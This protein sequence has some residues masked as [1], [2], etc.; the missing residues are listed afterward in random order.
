MTKTTLR[1]IRT[2]L[3]ALPAELDD[4]YDQVFRRIRGQDSE[5]CRLALRTLGW[6]NCALRPLTI[7]ELLHATAVELED[8]TFDTEGIPEFSM[9][10]SVCAGL[11][12]VQRNDIVALVHYTASEYVRNHIEMLAIHRHQQLAQTCLAYLSMS[13]FGGD[14]SPQD[15]SFVNR[16]GQY[17]LL[18]YSS[19]HWGA[20]ARLANEE[21]LVS[22]ALSFL[23][24]ENNPVASIQAM[25]AKQSPYKG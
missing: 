14:P 12:T 4:M 22:P 10:E 18:S 21:Q 2:S 15:G 5:S 6:I 1:A 25:Q 20:H 16:L 24:T 8:T 7:P 9:L 11:I 13:D 19:C 17:P 3:Q 23:V